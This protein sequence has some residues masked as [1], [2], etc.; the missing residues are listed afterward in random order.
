MLIEISSHGSVLKRDHEV[1]VVI[2]KDK[3][4][5]E[6]PAEKVDCIMI[7]SNSVITT[8]AI[9][10]CL[11]KQIQLVICNFGGKPVARLWSSTPGKATQIRRTQY[12]ND[13]TALS[14]DFCKK[15]LLQKTKRQMQLLKE[16][17]HNRTKSTT[18]FDISNTIMSLQSIIEKIKKTQYSDVPWKPSFLGYEGSVASQYFGCVSSFLPT[19]WQFTKRSQYPAIDAFNSVLN[20]TYGLGYA[21]VEKMIIL[22]G[23]DPNAG[24]YHS[25]S[26]AKPTLSFDLIEPLRPYMDKL[27]VSLFTKK[28]AKDSWFTYNDDSSVSLD[29]D[30]RR[31]IINN[32]RQDYVKKIEQESWDFCSYMIKNLLENRT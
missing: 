13:D 16:L 17:A 3:T 29:V 6:I 21:S 4:R 1:F 22:S 8:Q 24:F 11:E 12:L 14:F 27:A 30:A 26:Y 28:Q 20:Y 31:H 19:K 5:N 25:D 10:L 15:L 2:S 9:R 18:S 23:L 7:T 32:Y